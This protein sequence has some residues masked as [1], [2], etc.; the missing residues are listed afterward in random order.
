MRPYE[1]E[2]HGSKQ[3]RGGLRPAECIPRPHRFIGQGDDRHPGKRVL[4]VPIADGRRK[5]FEFTP[6]R[7]RTHPLSRF[8][9]FVAAD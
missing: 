9:I 2:T 8:R 3:Q 4:A 1:L 5:V 6:R 7:L